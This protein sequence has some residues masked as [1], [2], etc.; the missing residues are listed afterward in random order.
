[1]TPLGRM[2]PFSTCGSMNVLSRLSYAIAALAIIVA[3]LLWRRPELALP[4]FAAKYGGSVLWG[5]MVFCFVGALVPAAGLG[6]IALIAALVAAAVEFS[7]AV[8]IGWLDAFRATTFGRLLLGQTFAWGD[9]VAYWIGIAA[10]LAVA[11]CWGRR[12]S[13]SG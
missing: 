5:A 9:V 10:A 11:A 12:P 1:M 13:R 3:G 8:H 2:S 7:Q 6:R 4:P